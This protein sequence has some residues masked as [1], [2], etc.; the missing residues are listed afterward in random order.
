MGSVRGSG[1]GGSGTGMAGMAGISVVCVSGQCCFDVAPIR[2]R[3]APQPCASRLKAG[4]TA[5]GGAEQRQVGRSGRGAG[6]LCS[7]RQ[8]YTTHVRLCGLCGLCTDLTTPLAVTPFELS[9]VT[10]PQRSS[11]Q[12]SISWLCT[13]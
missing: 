5:V 12:R 7:V 6:E 10:R 1:S 8:R 2:L 13:E 4:Q 11:I 9:S 3:I